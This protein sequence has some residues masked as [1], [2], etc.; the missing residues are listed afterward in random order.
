MVGW[1]HQLHEHEFEQALED[2][3]GQGSLAYCSPWG[4]RESD[5]TEQLNNEQYILI[6]K[7]FKDVYSRPLLG[8]YHCQQFG[9]TCLNFQV[10]YNLQSK[11][12]LI[13]TITP[14]VYSI[15]IFY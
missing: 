6:E 2:G 7:K 12:L 1:H 3:E 13:F 4:C 15:F 11:H 5:T 8:G 9:Q 10:I 14:M